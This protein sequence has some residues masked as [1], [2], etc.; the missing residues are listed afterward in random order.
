MAFWAFR[1]N[2]KLYDLTARLTD[3]RE[4][5]TWTVRQHAKRIAPGDVAFLWETGP[6]RGFRGI[7][8]IDSAPAV[9]PE[10]GEELAFWR[11]GMA[12]EELRVRGVLVDRDFTLPYSKM[13][14]DEQ[15]AALAE[16]L[17]SAM[18]TNI[19]LS[20]EEGELLLSRSE[21]EL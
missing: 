18:G 3:P 10:L 8:R 1:C 11:D 4:E 14:E 15:F 6:G 21:A 2:P 7:M 17:K 9:E 13:A 16:R 20:D 12:A 19:P 5:Q